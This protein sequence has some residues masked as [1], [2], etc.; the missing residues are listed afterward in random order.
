MS[1]KKHIVCFGDSNTFGYCADPSDTRSGWPGRFGEDERWP[2]L[3][4][5]L[6][7][8]E[9]L[10]IEEGLSGRTT[11][12]SDPLREGRDGLSYI[13]PCLKSHEPVDLL[14]VMLGTND[15]KERYNV[16]AYCISMGMERLVK[17]AETTDCWASAPKVLVVAPPPIDP[18]MTDTE[19]VAAMGRE[20]PA[21]TA[22]LAGYYRAAAKANGWFFLDAA[23][24]E[25]NATDHMHLTRKAHA[26]LAERMAA[27]VRKIL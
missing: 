15:S 19:V 10:V 14:I 3:M 9:Y 24:C 21:K 27:E 20:A 4:Q 5:A 26:A 16:G 25:M 6:L 22:A 18:R 11:V 7:G 8:E 12:F 17:K 1:M 2:R 23:G 13:T